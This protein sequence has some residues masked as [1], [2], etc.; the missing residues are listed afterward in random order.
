M[1]PVQRIRRRFLPLMHHAR[2]QV[3]D[4]RL[5]I[6]EVTQRCNVACRHCG[7][8]CV[9]HPDQP[10]LP[11]ADVVRVLTEV[12]GAYDSRKIMVMVIGGEPL[13]YPGFWELG[14]Q[15][16]KLEYPWGLVTNG[17]AWTDRDFK[18]A[19]RAHLDSVAVSLDGLEAEHDAMRGRKGS[20]DRTLAM[21][22]HLMEDRFWQVMDVVT[23]VTPENLPVL[24]GIYDLLH[25]LG[26]PA[27][28]LMPV[29]PLGRAATHPDL[30]LD[31]AGFKQLM[32]K[33]LEFKARNEMM[34]NLSESHY[35]GP[36]LEGRVRD[37]YY[38]C[39]AGIHAAG[40][41]VN[42]DIGACPNLDR[43]LRQGN[44]GEDS[45]VDVWENRYHL[46][47]DRRW[48]RVGACAGCGEWRWCQ[49]NSLHNWDL[50]AGRPKQC[51]FQQMR[52]D[53]FPG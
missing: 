52:L 8:D 26:I 53:R 46:F 13:C 38:Y 6:F 29:S 51:H 44:L 15:I 45:F 35:L 47:R 20:F 41:M 19:R 34:V 3:H 43:R 21:L 10:D 12:R 49:G 48:M 1:N 31:E 2:R 37:H 23:C 50:L 9:S 30:F 5:L 14:R 27:W 25:G 28:R 16:R 4:L 7:S 22:R 36:C 11:M 42:G 24:D 18:E 39:Q 40:I 33:I 17:Y 32:S